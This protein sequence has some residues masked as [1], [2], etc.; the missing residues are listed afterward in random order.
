MLMASTMAMVSNDIKQVW[1]YSTI[2][3]LGFMI[4]GLAA[5]SF[6]A[7]LFHL[8]THA[9]FKALLFLCS[10]VFIHHFE[11]NDIR[12]I[13]QK[14][15]RSLRLPMICMT[16]AAAA[17]SGLPPLSGFFS[18]EAILGALA[19]LDNPIWLIFGLLGVFLTSYYAFRLIF[20][21][22]RPKSI[23]QHDFHETEG[24]L[25]ER[26]M[27]I[28]LAVLASITLILGFCQKALYHFL[29]PA[30]TAGNGVHI[31]AHPQ[32]LPF[33]ALG[34]ALIGIL[35]A[36]FEFGRKDAKRIGFLEKSPRIFQLF[37]QRWYLDHFY[38]RLLD[39]VVYR[40]LSHTFNQ[41]DH[42]IIDGGIDGMANGA[43][44][45]GRLLTQLQSGLFQFRLKVI[46]AVMVLAGLYILL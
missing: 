33:I 4:M 15:G 30:E 40:G 38:R 6:F 44:S 10:G 22:L 24:D 5:G 7:G 41:N 23:A 25:G 31:N 14:G 21:I 42:R 16:I 28:A 1:A 2:S 39:Q 43:L 3:Q 20:L 9:G 29:L 32:L 8:T 17:L 18:K 34:L 12:T 13:G 45:L 11:T 35:I 36:F 26:F 37:S 46:F 19:E 27:A